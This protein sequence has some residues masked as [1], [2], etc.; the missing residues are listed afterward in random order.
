MFGVGVP[1]VGRPHPLVLGRGQVLGPPA[2]GGVAHH[3]PP[4]QLH[5]GQVPGGRPAGGV[6]RRQAAGLQVGAGPVRVVAEYEQ[7]GVRPGAGGGGHRGGVVGR[8]TDLEDRVFGGL[9]IP[10]AQVDADRVGRRPDLFGQ[11]PCRR[12]RAAQFPADRRLGA[13]KIPGALEIAPAQKV[14]GRAP[15]HRH[16]PVGDKV[17]PCQ[18]EQRG[19]AG[20]EAVP[21]PGHH[22]AALFG[23]DHQGLGQVLPGQMP[24][25][26]LRLGQ[27]AHPGGQR[28]RGEGAGGVGG[29]AGLPV[30]PVQQ[31]Q[32]LPAL[33]GQ[34]P[35]EG[36]DKHLVAEP[37]GKFCVDHLPPAN[38][39]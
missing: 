17:Q 39:S 1:A 23:L 30:P 32:F 4:A 33:Q 36:I 19:H 37:A 11:R 31:G 34:R 9:V 5:Q 38:S 15:A 18:V 16:I 20:F 25:G 28:Q 22:A 35:P 29:C 3:K 27:D 14:P 10:P 13:G 21:V 7:P 26:V 8:R 2:V 24:F 6:G 12:G